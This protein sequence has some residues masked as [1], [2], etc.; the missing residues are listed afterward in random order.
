ML[1]EGCCDQRCC[2]VW[3]R[4]TTEPYDTIAKKHNFDEWRDVE[5]R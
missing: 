5:C 2:L 4:E 1:S 3:L